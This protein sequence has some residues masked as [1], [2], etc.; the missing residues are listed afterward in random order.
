MC[1]TAISP[2]PPPGESTGTVTPLFVVP[3]PGSGAV[4]AGP[5]RLRINSLRRGGGMSWEYP[6][7]ITWGRISYGLGGADDTMTLVWRPDSATAY[8]AVA[9]TGVGH[10]A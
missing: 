1:P 9:G 5:V 10:F 3:T 7:S 4:T 8:A 6:K 2:P